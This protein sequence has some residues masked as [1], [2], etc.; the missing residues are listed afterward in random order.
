MHKV[1]YGYH[2][3]PERLPLIRLKGRYLARLGFG[4]GDRIRVRIYKGKITI[5]KCT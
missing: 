4:V 3:G 5:T 2:R 1:Q